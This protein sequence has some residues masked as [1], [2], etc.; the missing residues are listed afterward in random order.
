MTA[1]ATTASAPSVAQRLWAQAQ[2]RA[3]QSLYHPFVAALAAGTLERADFQAFLLQDAYYL[4]GFA[5][6]FAHAVVKAKDTKHAL[7]V[8]RL[9]G[10]IEEELSNHTA[11]LEVRICLQERDIELSLSLVVYQRTLVTDCSHDAHISRLGST[12]SR[13][14]KRQLRQRRSSTSTSCSR[15]RRRGTRW[16]R[17]WLR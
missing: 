1:T 2:A 8:I 14:K 7:A 6:A 15:L 12:C 4:H 10:G 3:L 5:K 9:M 17:S 13:S 16:P 11:F